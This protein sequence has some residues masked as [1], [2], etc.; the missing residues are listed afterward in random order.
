MK[1]KSN[2]SI[3]RRLIKSFRNIQRKKIKNKKLIIRRIIK[4]SVIVLNHETIRIMLNCGSEINLIK[5]Y[6]VK[7]LNLKACAL[8]DIDLIILDNK[9]F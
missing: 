8:K 6:F 4:I 2:F 3:N 9:S 5:K 7:K 1:N